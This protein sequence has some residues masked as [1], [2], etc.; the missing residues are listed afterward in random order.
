MKISK[1][2]K[3]S[4]KPVLVE[5]ISRVFELSKIAHS[6][7]QARFIDA[8]VGAGGHSIEIVKAKVEVLG[9]DADE[10]MLKVAEKN[11]EL[12]C[13]TP[14][15]KV[16]GLFKLV[17][18]NFRNIDKI[19]KEEGFEDVDGILFDLGI[20][21]FHYDD[22]IRGFSFKDHNA[23]LDMRLDPKAQK[24]KASDLLNGL[25]PDQ[26]IDLFSLTMY[27]NEAK[28]LANDVVQLRSEK[29]L[30]TVGDIVNLT[31]KNTRKS[32]LHPA[33]K[34][35]LSLRM[36]VNSEL[37]NL[38]VSLPKAFNLLKEG[39]KLIVISFHSGEDSIVKK[40]FSELVRKGQ[41]KLIFKKPL[42]PN[43]D[44]IKNNPRARSAKMRVIKKI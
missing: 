28:K 24:V 32:K 26:L 44:E 9:I 11:L 12:A 10:K 37:D 19:S 17:H 2:R 13:P 33:T 18:G 16:R 29:N 8:T 1:E 40:Q 25:R 31:K 5:E 36:A 6:K 3:L 27:R 42:V 20:S 41:G 23:D 35:F 38:K 14:N 43:E 7:T 22:D 4:H 30:S 15:G 21:S 34:A 39:G